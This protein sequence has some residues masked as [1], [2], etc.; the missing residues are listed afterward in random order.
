LH[1]ID[2]GVLLIALERMSARDGDKKHCA[3]KKI[4]FFTMKQL[5]FKSNSGKH[6]RLLNWGEKNASLPSSTTYQRPNNGHHR[7]NP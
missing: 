1:N 6:H 4:P 5:F 3:G 7:N 2:T